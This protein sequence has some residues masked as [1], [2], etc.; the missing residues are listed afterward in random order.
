VLLRRVKVQGCEASDGEGRTWSILIEVRP[1][2][3]EVLRRYD[4]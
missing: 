3:D 2:G 1:S 4:K